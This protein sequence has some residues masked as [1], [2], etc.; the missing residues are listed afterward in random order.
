MGFFLLPNRRF[1][2]NEEREGGVC[3]QQNPRK[4]VAAMEWLPSP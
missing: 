2:E 3:C 4:P 1:L